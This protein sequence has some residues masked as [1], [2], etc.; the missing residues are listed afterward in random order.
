MSQFIQTLPTG[1]IPY[2]FIS[3]S[4]LFDIS[5][6][7]PNLKFFVNIPF[8]VSFFSPDYNILRLLNVTLVLFSS[9]FKIF[10]EV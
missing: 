5:F 2:I 4:G 1:S 6:L 3:Q 10:I 8:D 9:K 7:Y